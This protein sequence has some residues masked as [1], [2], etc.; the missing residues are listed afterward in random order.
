MSTVLFEIPEGSTEEIGPFTLKI[1]G[2]VTPLSGLTVV[3]IL[4]NTAGD[5]VTYA[6]TLRVGTPSSLG[7]VYI[8]PAVTD[9]IA[10]DENEYHLRFQTTN[11]SGQKGYYPDGEA[12]RV[13]VW[14]K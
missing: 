9:F 13:I 2:V 1:A 11:G 7:Q 6:G 3:P 4:R 14:P 5:L 12:Y 10:G 8:T